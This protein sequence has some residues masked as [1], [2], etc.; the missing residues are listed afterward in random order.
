M[1]TPFPRVPPNLDYG[2]HWLSGSSPTRLDNTAPFHQWYPGW[3]MKWD[4]F[5]GGHEPGPGTF[6]LRKLPLIPISLSCSWPGSLSCHEWEILFSEQWSSSFFVNFHVVN[7]YSWASSAYQH[8]KSIPSPWGLGLPLV[9]LSDSL[10]LNLGP[11]KTF[12]MLDHLT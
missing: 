1:S 12:L 4:P 10:C 5:S 7:T 6:K 11:D 3:L 2:G 9:V 8:S